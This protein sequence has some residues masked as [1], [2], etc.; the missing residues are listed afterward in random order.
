[1]HITSE[2]SKYKSLNNKADLVSLIREHAKIK[3]KDMKNYTIKKLKQY[4]RPQLFCMF[5][6]IEK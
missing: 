3:G 1:M 2:A 6:G 5:C 4:P